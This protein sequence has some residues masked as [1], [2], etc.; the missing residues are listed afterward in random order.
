MKDIMWKVKWNITLAFL[1]LK[2]KALNTILNPCQ[3]FKN[4]HNM[5]IFILATGLHLTNGELLK[6]QKNYGEGDI[7]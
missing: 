1:F 4:N 3:Y 2:I 7:L 5:P 6:S